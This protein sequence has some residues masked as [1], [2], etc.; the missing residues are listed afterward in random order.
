MPFAGDVMAKKKLDKFVKA[1]QKQAR[2]ITKDLER[3]LLGMKFTLEE[4]GKRNATNDFYQAVTRSGMTRDYPLTGR[5]RNSINARIKR[6]P[7]NVEV[8]LQAGGLSGG[9]NVNYAGALEFG[10][11][12]M[13]PFFFLGRAV[14][15]EQK[16]IPKNLQKFLKI[17]LG[18]L[19]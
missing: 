15:A 1:T 2:E 5:L 7:D 10:H 14:Q 18:D 13:K 9:G 4:K 3:Y 11:G 19:V 17:E 12:R 16:T 8:I 6:K